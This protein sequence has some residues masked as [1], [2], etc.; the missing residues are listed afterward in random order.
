[1]L[2]GP[3]RVLINDRATCIVC[4]WNWKEDRLIYPLPSG[5]ASSW[6]GL[7]QVNRK[8]S[9]SKW[10]LERLLLDQLLKQDQKNIDWTESIKPYCFGWFSILFVIM[11]MCSME[12]YMH[13]QNQ[14]LL[15]Q[16]A[17]GW[18][19]EQSSAPGYSYHYCGDSLLRIILGVLSCIYIV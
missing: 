19:A 12:H 10:P 8:F 5:E 9:I 1:M 15:N 6:K 16:E 11:R 7:F 18:L 2:F 4:G 17:V 13:G 14:K 3:V